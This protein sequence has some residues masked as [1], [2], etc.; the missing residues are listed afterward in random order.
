MRLQP[1]LGQQSDTKPWQGYLQSSLNQFLCHIMRSISLQSSFKQ[2]QETNIWD[3]AMAYETL[4]KPRR[5]DYMK[6]YS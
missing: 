3:Q 4:T 6:I 1:S 5:N 2:L